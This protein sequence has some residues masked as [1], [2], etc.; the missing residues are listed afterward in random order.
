MYH[1]QENETLKCITTNELRN[2]AE[3]VPR[4]RKYRLSWKKSRHFKGIWRLGNIKNIYI[5]VIMRVI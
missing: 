3:N 2:N 4:D 1:S 5:N